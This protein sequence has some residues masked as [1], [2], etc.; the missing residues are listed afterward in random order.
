M[1]GCIFILVLSADGCI[2]G[3]FAVP[4]LRGT[5]E[6]GSDE[7]SLKPLEDLEKRLRG[8]MEPLGA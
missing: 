8:C 6:G 3:L 4:V 7:V 2:K 5:W 1:G